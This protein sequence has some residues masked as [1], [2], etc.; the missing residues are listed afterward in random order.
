MSNLNGLVLYQPEWPGA[1]ARRE[2]A[3]IA[4]VA[5]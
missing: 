1:I 4:K 2:R 5:S 3:N